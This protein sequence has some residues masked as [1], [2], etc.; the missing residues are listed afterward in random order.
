M[1]IIPVGEFQSMTTHDLVE[2]NGEEIYL[3]D[4][5]REIVFAKVRIT[6][7]MIPLKKKQEFTLDI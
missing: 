3:A 4:T 2:L 7:A 1:K 5:K 6:E